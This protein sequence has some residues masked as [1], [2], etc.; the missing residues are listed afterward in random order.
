MCGI[1]GVFNE[2][3]EAAPD[4]YIGLYA[5]QHR[6]K[7]SARIVTGNGERFYEDGGM[8]EIPAV[9]SAETLKRFSGKIGI[10][11][12]RYSTT[13]SSDPT[14]IQPIQE[15][16]KGEEF[17]L[18]HNG[19][20]VNTEEIRK[21]CFKRGKKP[22][23][24]SDSGAIATLISLSSAPSFEEAVKETVE[25][26]KGAF[27]ILILKKDELIALRDKL[28]IR[29]LHLGQRGKDLMV[30]S[31]TCVF[32]HLGAVLVREIKPGEI[33]RITKS[34]AEE[35]RQLA[36]KNC[37]R[38]I[39]EY[40][41]FERPDSIEQGR[42]I[43][44]ARER[45]GRFLAR[46]QPAEADIVIP[47]PDSG[48]YGGFGFIKESEIKDGREALFRPHLVSRTFIEPVHEF[49]EKGIELKLVILDEK[50]AG[51]RVV[52][53]DD[54]IVR[55]TTA[56]RLIERLRKAGAEEVHIRIHS[57]MYRHPCYFGIDTYRVKDELLAA[58]H[59]GDI[60]KMR[61]E[62]GADSLGYLSLESVIMAI[63]ETPGEPL[64]KDGFCTACFDAKYPIEPPENSDFKPPS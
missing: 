62:I 61:Q 11:H 14:N 55:G 26:L 24:S 42:R 6:G 13:S 30:A 49:R 33:L 16:W 64:T 12:N 23:T 19:N 28:A 17:W 43:C 18:A 27:S 29:P 63:I 53:I 57:P 20:L 52:L 25:K 34:G 45:M 46:E 10:A 47:V 58:R 8:G 1:V 38:C 51:E 15:F 4:C 54:S 9:F 5:L 37:K 2:L 32:Y 39:F 59:K 7:E 36:V 35:Y 44:E 48:I 21:E 50:V 31:E 22:A 60:E 40:I 56:R 41:Y 3:K